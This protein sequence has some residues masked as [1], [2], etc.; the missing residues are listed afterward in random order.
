[1]PVWYPPSLLLR[2]APRFSLRGPS[3]PRVSHPAPA[4]AWPTEHPIP[5]HSDRFGNDDPNPKGF[6]DHLEKENV[7]A[8]QVS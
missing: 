1:M 4:Q 3:L 2:A 6:E 7:S 8:P 5:N